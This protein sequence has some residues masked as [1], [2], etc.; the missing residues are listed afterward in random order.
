MSK[1]N[2]AIEDVQKF[3]TMFGGI[4]ELAEVLKEIPGVEN[5][6]AEL[7]NQKD[8]LVIDIENINTHATELEKKNSLDV[9]NNIKMIADAEKKA[10][11]IVDEATK[12]GDNL[13]NLAKQAF[14]KSE[15]KIK[16]DKE[17]FN[18]K[19]RDAEKALESL[20]S[21]IES[22]QKRLDLIKAEIAKIKGL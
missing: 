5:H 9:L 21:E 19:Y 18:S 2:K 14:E 6:I 10:K 1:F 12:N 17:E 8:A 13:M 3:Q 22:E 7:K 16:A 4:L 20:K 11:S 15:N